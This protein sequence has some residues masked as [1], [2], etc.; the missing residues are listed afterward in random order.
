MLTQITSA[1]DF[2][3]A[4]AEYDQLS[5]LESRDML[6]DGT[7][8]RL[9]QLNA[10]LEAAPFEFD[11]DTGKVVPKQSPEHHMS[12]SDDFVDNAVHSAIKELKKS[13]MYFTTDQY[14]MLNDRITAFLREDC[15]LDV[16]P[17]PPVNRSAD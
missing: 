16:V 5:D 10:M 1:T 4:N 14:M 12:I 3:A 11:M 13:G 15:G 7:S 6:S 8:Q 9:E 2:K 17:T